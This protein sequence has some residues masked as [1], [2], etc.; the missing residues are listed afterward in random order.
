MEGFDLPP[1]SEKVGVGALYLALALALALALL[2]RVVVLCVNDDFVDRG[3]ANRLLNTGERLAG[4]TFLVRVEEKELDPDALCVVISWQ[5][6]AHELWVANDLPGHDK[7]A[8]VVFLP[9]LHG[10]L[11]GSEDLALERG[12]HKRLQV[13]ASLHVTRVDDKVCCGCWCLRLASLARLKLCRVLDKSHGFLC[14]RV[15]V[16]LCVG[17]G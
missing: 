16:C 10:A 4:G 11:E 15:C 2:V 1:C 5:G 7:V 17:K 14:A 12:V 3:D 13:V 6:H 9:A 8:L